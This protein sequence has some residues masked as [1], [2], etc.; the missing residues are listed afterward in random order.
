MLDQLKNQVESL[1]KVTEFRFVIWLTG[2][3]VLVAI[4]IYVVLK[5]RG[6]VSGNMQVSEDHLAKFRKLHQQGAIDD[7]E[8]VRVKS[9]VGKTIRDEL[10]LTDRTDKT[11]QQQP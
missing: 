4:A 5:I 8:F 11:D 10:N 1:M 6:Q 3:A 2:L 7:K 9:V